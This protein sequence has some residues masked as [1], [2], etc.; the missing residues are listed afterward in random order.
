MLN[1]NKNPDYNI[2]NKK[3]MILAAGRGTRLKPLTNTKPKALIEIEGIPLVEIIIKQLIF[4]GFDDIII[5]IHHFADQ[6]IEYIKKKHQFG[7][8]ISFSDERDFLLD[9]GGGIK[10]AA[11]FFNDNKPFLVHNVD[12]ISD[13]DLNALYQYHLTN[14]PLVT[15]AVKDR[16]TS[17]SLLINPQNELCGWV[18][19]QSGEL[20]L[21]RNN[22]NDLFPIAYSCVQIISPK[23][24]PLLNESGA[25]SIIDSYLR[26]CVTEKILTYQH[27]GLWIDLGKLENITE[28]SKHLGKLMS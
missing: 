14:N 24:F 16:P 20:K 12:I 2:N 8:N 26:L 1:L 25:F 4:Y 10:K 21:M 6:I 18:N 9:T 28:A 15:L 13:L 19:N 3:A 27:E 22:L 11:S 23:I 7:I 17:R 5:N